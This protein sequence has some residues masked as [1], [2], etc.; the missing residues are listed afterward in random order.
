[1]LRTSTSLTVTPPILSV[2]MKIVGGF[3]RGVG[4]LSMAASEVVALEMHVS[5]FGGLA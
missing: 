1:V 4:V 2:L 5:K 3:E